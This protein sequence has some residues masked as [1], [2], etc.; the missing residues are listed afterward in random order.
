[1]PHPVRIPLRRLPHIIPCENTSQNRLS[2][3]SQEE[4]ESHR[5]SVRRCSD[6]TTQRSQTTLPCGHEV[7][8][9]TNQ[10]TN[11]TRFDR[12][13]E[14]WKIMGENYIPVGLT[15]GATGAILTGAAVPAIVGVG[16]CCTL[17][18]VMAGGGIALLGGCALGSV[19]VSGKIIYDLCLCEWE[20]YKI[21]MYAGLDGDYRSLKD[22]F[23]EIASE[24]GN[25]F[26]DAFTKNA[27]VRQA[28]ESTDKSSPSRR[29]RL[30]RQYSREV[31]GTFPTC[32]YCLSGASPPPEYIA[33]AIDFL[34]PPAYDEEPEPIEL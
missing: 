25:F 15:A 17:S 6:F 13:E 5:F 20:H 23:K 34:P 33:T 26:T 28:S 18:I 29:R 2:V 27:T 19:V 21:Q 24:L 8:A 11:E 22:E 4:D 1:M 12:P 9:T 31:S 10:Y 30:L 3:I 14:D 32:P 16:A 7:I